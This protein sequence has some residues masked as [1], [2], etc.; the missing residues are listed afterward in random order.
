MTNWQKRVLVAVIITATSVLYNNWRTSQQDNKQIL[1]K[2]YFVDKCADDS[3]AATIGYCGCIYDGL[4]QKIGIKNAVADVVGMNE[5]EVINYYL[6][7]HREIV[8][9]CLRTS[10]L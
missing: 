3:I 8:S 1:S 9:N 6:T 10:G 5:E 7:N 4:D 2:G